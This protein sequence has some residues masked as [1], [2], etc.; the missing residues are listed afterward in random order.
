M[1]LEG[2][3]CDFTEMSGT[4][5]S[6]QCVFYN[7]Q[8]FLH[9]SCILILL[10]LSLHIVFL[11]YKLGEN[12]ITLPLEVGNNLYRELKNVE[13]QIYLAGFRFVTLKGKKRNPGLRN[14]VRKGA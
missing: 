6:P 9:S 5:Q 8:E 7:L 4:F 13:K 12:N 11:L 2:E 1:R 14:L 10:S 3:T